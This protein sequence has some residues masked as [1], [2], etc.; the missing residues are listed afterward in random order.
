MANEYRYLIESNLVVVNRLFVLVY[1]NQYGNSKR[2]RAKAYY[3]PKGMIKN[4]NVII[5]AKKS[6]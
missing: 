3:L 6:L 2:F 4:Y 5:N 1:S